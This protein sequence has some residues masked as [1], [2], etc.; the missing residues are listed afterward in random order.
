MLAYLRSW[1]DDVVVCVNNLSRFPQ[2]VEL[3][4]SNY[5][6]SQPVELTGGVPFQ[7]HELNQ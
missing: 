3:D 4:L 1:N 5:R 2:P 6:G 7:Q